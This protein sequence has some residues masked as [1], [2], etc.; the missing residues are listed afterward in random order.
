MV[1]KGSVGNIMSLS[2]AVM[3]VDEDEA[4]GLEDLWWLKC[5]LADSWAYISK[6]F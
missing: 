1:I 4:V 6:E 3:G 2:F 5:H